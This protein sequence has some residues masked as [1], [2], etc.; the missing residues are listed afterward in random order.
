MDRISQIKECAK[1]VVTSAYMDGYYIKAEDLDKMSEEEKNDP[2]IKHLRT[3]YDMIDLCNQVNTEID[4]CA[5]VADIISYVSI[6]GRNNLLPFTYMVWEC[7][8]DSELGSLL[9]ETWISIDGGNDNNLISWKTWARMFKRADKNT[10]M[11]ESERA[12]LASQD[13]MMTVY[14]GVDSRNSANKRALSWSA[15]Y[16]EAVWFASRFKDF[17]HGGEVWRLTIPK[18]KIYCY[19]EER[20]ESECVVSPYHKGYDIEVILSLD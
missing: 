11:T 20:G 17:I 6:S 7:M 1:K 14:R 4:N 5:S 8:D 12:W 3:E 19:F 13:N 15:D 10:L 18:D 16:D 2:V 9:A